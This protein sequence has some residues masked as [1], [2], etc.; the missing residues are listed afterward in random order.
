M[1][2]INL[3]SIGGS[4][5][6]VKGVNGMLRLV[7]AQTKPL[8]CPPYVGNMLMMFYLAIV[9]YVASHGFYMW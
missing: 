3:E 6:D 2:K 7:W 8:F 1:E 9:S 5:A 4:L